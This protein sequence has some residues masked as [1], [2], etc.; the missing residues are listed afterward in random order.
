M[1]CDTIGAIISPV[2]QHHGR[3]ICHQRG[4][5]A[6]GWHVGCIGRGVIDLPRIGT[7]IQTRIVGREIFQYVGKAPLMTGLLVVLHVSI[8]VRGVILTR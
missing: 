7:P 1:G 2:I 4:R 3:D 8:H 5:A 6:R